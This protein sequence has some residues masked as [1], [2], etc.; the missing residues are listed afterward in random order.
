MELK[1]C[2]ECNNEIPINDR[3]VRVYATVKYCNDVCYKQWK[4]KTFV[5]RK[6]SHCKEESKMT[7]NRYLC[8]ICQ[9]NYNKAKRKLNATTN[10]EPKP[11]LKEYINELHNLLIKIKI[12]GGE[13]SLIDCFRIT[14][15][16]VLLYNKKT[17]EFKSH[18][19]EIEFYT[20]CLI[21]YYLNYRDNTNIKLP[22]YDKSYVAH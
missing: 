11:Q 18:I 15:L 10:L 20:N 22:T 3:P 14:N 13:I 5:I 12:N 19:E 4:R 17:P 1:K 8:L 6:C 21:V 16:F 2:L 9:N 7:Y